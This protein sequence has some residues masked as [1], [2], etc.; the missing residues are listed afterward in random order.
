MNNANRMGVCHDIHVTEDGKCI[1]TLIPE[2]GKKIAVECIGSL[3]KI[4]FRKIH[5][6][7][8]ITVIGRATDDTELNYSELSGIRCAV[9]V[10][11]DD[12]VYPL[13]YP[14]EVALRE[15]ATVIKMLKMAK[16]AIEAYEPTDPF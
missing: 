11:E 9:I 1:F 13:D 15:K 8:K 14:K 12:T 2:V 6:G 4:V 3:N 10:T 7:D 16:A 5:N